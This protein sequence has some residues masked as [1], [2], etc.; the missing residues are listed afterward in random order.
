MNLPGKIKS[1]RIFIKKLSLLGGAT[2]LGS[3]L[4]AES[5]KVALIGDEICKGYYYYTSQYMAGKAE[6][7]SP[8]GETGN[9]T[10][11]QVNIVKW[12]KENQFDVIHFNSGLQDIR[13]IDFEY[14][15]NLVPLPY[16]V[17]NL[18]RVIMLIHRY[19][20][21]TSIVWATTTPVLDDRFLEFQKDIREY[22]ISN[23]EVIRYNEASVKTMGKMGVAVNDLYTYVMGGEPA[24]IM[25]NDGIHFYDEGYELLGERVAAAI[26]ILIK[27]G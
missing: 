9:T 10:D 5:K 27:N 20:P 21:R 16:Y 17:E 22:F 6:L 26:E 14:R 18:E 1:R 25:L 7:W 12:I 19:S 2:I 4:F 8:E 23:E 11:L 15:K 24:D 3:P 13:T